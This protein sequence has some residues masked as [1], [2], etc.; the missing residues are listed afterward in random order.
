MVGE[1]SKGKLLGVGLDAQDDQVRVTRGKNFHLV[2]GTKDTHE[3]MQEQCIKLNEKLD[4]RG[5]ELD[6]LERQEFLDLAAQ[7]GMN[8]AIPRE[9]KS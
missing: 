7:C 1:R 6:Q 5:K 8:V 4:A 3:T 2:G 9:T